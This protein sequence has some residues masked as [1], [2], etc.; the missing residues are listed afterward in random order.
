MTLPSVGVPDHHHAYVV[1]P[2]HVIKDMTDIEIEAANP[3]NEGTLYPPV[4]VPDWQKPTVRPNADLAFAP[5]K[6]PTNQT[7]IALPYGSLVQY[8]LE[9][10]LGAPVHYVGLLSPLGIPM[11]RSG[12]VGAIEV[13]G[14]EHDGP[15]EYAAHLLDCRSYDGFSGSPCYIEYP[16]AC[17]TPLDASDFPFHMP[18]DL[19]AD[20]LGSLAFLQLFCGM[21][22]EHFSDTRMAGLASNLG[23]GVVLPADHIIEELMTDELRKERQQEDERWLASQPPSVIHA[24]S[25]TPTERDDEFQRFEDLTRTPVQTPKPHH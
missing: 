7:V 14:M 15:Y 9:M 5:Y 4:P 8:G 22:T 1:T 25:A 6:I 23:T 3:Y 18:R 11:A 21:F 24:A 2:H 16:M 12:T 13:N 17:L 20:P 19:Q 10:R